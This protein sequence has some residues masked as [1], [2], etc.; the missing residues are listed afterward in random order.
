M[1][2]WQRS[3]TE[4]ID[5]Y[6]RGDFT[7]AEVTADVVGRI[8]AVNPQVNAIVVDLGDAAMAAAAAA[9]EARAAGAALGPLHGVPVTIKQNLD[10]EGQ[11]TPNGLAA[12]AGTIAPAD[13]AVVANLRRAGAIFVGR[14]NVPELSMR[15]TTSN[16]IDGATR[17]PWHPDASPGGSS[18]GAGAATVAG[19]GP[20]HHGNDIAGSLR[21]PAW[22]N[23]VT[24]IKPSQGRLPAYNPTATA[25]RGLLS[26]LMSAQGVLARTVADVRVATRA[27]AARDLRDPWWLPVPFDGPP[28]DP[29][30]RVAVT[31]NPHGYPIDPRIAALVERA[32][33]HL[34]DAGY[35]VEEVEPPP[36][37]DPARGWMSTGITEIELT[38]DASVRAYGSAELGAVFDAYYAMGELVDLVDY[39]AGLSDRTRMMRDWSLFLDHHPLV[40]TPLL[41]RPGFP[42][43][44]D[45]QGPAAVEDLFRSAIYSYGVNFLGLPAGVVPIDLVD[46]LPAGVQVIGARFRE[47]L[48]LDA[49]EAVES[50]AG[51]LFERPW[52]AWPA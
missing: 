44:Y 24:T 48:V 51:F 49:L 31:T 26:S 13:S 10:V 22:C 28:L 15:F 40:L 3:A 12:L 29:P 30:L 46:G 17:N 21:V 37:T 5:G 47:D 20:I 50:R 18:G 14:T 39:R 36:I 1:D 4:L 43:D 25:E 27:M 23:G 52:A 7:C 16:P 41:M 35:A 8:R 11:P 34:A 38:L 42:W 9:D 33:G 19:F 32:A 6:E 45:A 2:L